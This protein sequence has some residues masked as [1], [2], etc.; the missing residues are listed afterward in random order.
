[1][2]N[3]RQFLQSAG[4]AASAA[5]VALLLTELGC[6]SDDDYFGTAA[7]PTLPRCDGT[8]ATS[9]F[10]SGHTHEVCVPAADLAAPPA[11]GATYTTTLTSGHVHDIA[12]SRAQLEALGRGEAIGVSSTTTD[13]HAHAF[14]IRRS[15]R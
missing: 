11:E 1:M 4:C 7:D 13:G 5:T 15:G 10:A 14:S 6:S 12:V 2:I 8:S 9:T 3:R